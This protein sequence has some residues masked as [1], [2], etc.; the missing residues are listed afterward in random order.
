MKVHVTLLFCV[1]GALLYAQTQAPD[2]SSLGPFVTQSGGYSA[3]AAMP[4][5]EVLPGCRQVPGVFDCGVQV[6]GEFYIPNPLNGSRPLVIFL[7]GNHGTCG[8][9]YGTGA[10]DP[11]GLAGAP[12]MDRDF[13]LPTRPSDFTYTGTGTCSNRNPIVIPSYRGYDYLAERLASWGYIV[14]SIDANRGVQG[15]D[16]PAGVVGDPYLIRARG[17]LVLKT[18]AQLSF[19]NTNG[20]VPGSAVTCYR[21][22][23]ILAMSA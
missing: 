14:I 17:V 20:D 11:P 19:W 8:H 23:W 13:V 21:G 1:T 15:I 5:G 22:T 18:L 4:D 3:G 2:A 6:S 12:L 10:G 16:G 7:H 9:A